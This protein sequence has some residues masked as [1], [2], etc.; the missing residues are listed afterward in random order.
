MGTVVRPLLPRSGWQ[1]GTDVR[2]S[3]LPP[4]DAPKPLSATFPRYSVQTLLRTMGALALGYIL[5]LAYLHYQSEAE[6]RRRVGGPAA[7][8]ALRYAEQVE[9]YRIGELADR[10]NWQN[11]G[12]AD[13]PIL[14]GPLAVAPADIQTLTSTL[15]D[16]DSYSRVPKGCTPLPGVRVD[17]VHGNDRLSVLL[18]FECDSALYYLNDKIAGGGNFDPAR[19]ALVRIVR[20]LFPNDP[21]I[22]SLTEQR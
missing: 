20:P 8:A 1:V 7:L 17:F 6:M 9:A 18:C 22:Q 13:Y 16:R 5:L 19:P 14:K 3:R 4:T 10:D 21:K 12:L 15:Q 11:A 2:M